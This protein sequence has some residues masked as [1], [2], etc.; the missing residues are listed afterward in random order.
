MEEFKDKT[1][2]KKVDNAAER[3]C[4]RT[5]NFGERQKHFGQ[6]LHRLE[7]IRVNELETKYRHDLFD[8]IDRKDFAKPLE[9]DEGC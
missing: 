5:D 3:D 8:C 7:S 6:V 9:W 4:R 1:G 2:K